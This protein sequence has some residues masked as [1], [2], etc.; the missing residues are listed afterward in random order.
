MARG[1]VCGVCPR[2][3]KIRRGTIIVWMK[4]RNKQLSVSFTGGGGGVAGHA[5]RPGG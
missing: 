5:C 4:R 1:I 2:T 3:K